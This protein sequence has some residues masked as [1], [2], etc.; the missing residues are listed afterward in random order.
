MLADSSALEVSKR[1]TTQLPATELFTGVA[2]QAATVAM[3]NIA[4]A[5]DRLLRASEPI[6]DTNPLPSLSGAVESCACTVNPAGVRSCTCPSS[7]PAEAE[8]AKAWLEIV[9]VMKQVSARRL[10]P[11]APNEGPSSLSSCR[12]DMKS[13]R[14]T[15]NTLSSTSVVIDSTKAPGNLVANVRL[16][17]L[18][19]AGR[20][21]L[22]LPANTDP[23][24]VRVDFRVVRWVDDPLSF[25]DQGKAAV[26]ASQVLTVDF[27]DSCT[28]RRGRCLA[29]TCL[30]ITVPLYSHT[31]RT[32]LLVDSTLQPATSHI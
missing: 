31:C 17:N 18:V 27:V 28:S 12:I 24:D 11:R 7:S 6:T 21:A 8:A 29:C 32:C 13:Y 1:A 14:R 23:N 16:P 3:S 19:E 22:G 15:L 25:A 9:E 4:T 5:R 26:V 10:A 30:F 20:V 2:A